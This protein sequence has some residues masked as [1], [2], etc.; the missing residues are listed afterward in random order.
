MKISTRQYNITFQ[1][2]NKGLITK[3]TTVLIFGVHFPD[4]KFLGFGFSV[5]IGNLTH[6][7]SNVEIAQRITWSCF[8]GPMKNKFREKICATFFLPRFWGYYYLLFQYIYIYNFD[9]LAS[10]TIHPKHLIRLMDNLWRPEEWNEIHMDKFRRRGE[11][12][13]IKVFLKRSVV[14]C[15]SLNNVTFIKH[16]YNSSSIFLNLYNNV[17]Y[18][19]KLLN[20]WTKCYLCPM[21]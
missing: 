19:P 13:E 21:Y 7:N 1:E 2:K 10:I 15:D 11:W 14:S 3:C 5:K 16:L 4:L 12:N 20:I 17:N 18:Q 6:F 9:N 8:C